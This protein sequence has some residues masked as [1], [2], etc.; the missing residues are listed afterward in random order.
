M[1]RGPRDSGNIYA[2]F[3]C[4]SILI[5]QLFPAFAQTS[6]QK[7]E[8]ATKVIDQI[9]GC[10]RNAKEAVLLPRDDVQCLDYQTGAKFLGEK[11]EDMPLKIDVPNI[12]KDPEDRRTL[13]GSAIKTIARRQ[14]STVDPMGI[15]IIGAIFCDP[16]DLIGLELPYSLVV[17]KSIFAQGIQAR[18]FRTHGDLS[19]D[20][21]LVFDE[22]RLARI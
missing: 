9:I 2:T 17:D 12:C 6:A 13:P 20:K 22:L 16:L 11:T 15:R 19:L 10:V 3:I 8:L 7:A 1:H 5:L 4:A 21:S 14:P 18:T